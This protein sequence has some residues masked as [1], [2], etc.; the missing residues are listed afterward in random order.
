MAGI[1][2][3]IRKL[4]GR[5]EISSVLAAFVYSGIVSS[6]PWLFAVF[7]LGMIASVGKTLCDAETVN[8]FMGIIIYVFAFSTVL[9]YGTQMAITRFLADCLYR[10]EDNRIPSLLLTSLLLL[11]GIVIVFLTPAIW[12][13]ELPFQVRVQTVFLLV[14][15]TC[16][17]GAMIF[18]ST[19][20]AYVQVSIA[21]VFGFGF[22][23]PASL[24]IG[25]YFGLIG[26]LFGLNFGIAFVVFT[27]CALILKEFSGNLTIEWQVLRA[28]T[29]YPLLFF[30]GLTAGIGIWCDKFI[31]WLHFKIPIGAGLI[32][33]PM[34]DSAMF[35]GYMTVLPSLAYFILIAET[36]L[37]DNIRKYTYLINN[38]GRYE[39]L[40]KVRLNLVNCLKD[41]FIKIG[42]FQ[43]ILT[44]CGITTA[45]VW[46]SV[47][48]LSPLQISILR[49]AMLGAFFQIGMM[50]F[51]IVLT[52]I[53]GERDSFW[54]V[55]IFLGLNS[56]VTYLTL[57]NIWVH[58]YGYFAASFVGFFAAVFF[59]A[60]R[61]KHLHYYL[62]CDPKEL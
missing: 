42:I 38:H 2:F 25:K 59:V 49:I 4:L 15:V 44:I 18:V 36:D 31:F 37:Y 56:S 6:G 60:F 12:L 21:F 19:L 55:L 24:I 34:Y 17:W 33:Y 51:T 3:N 13:L 32:G 16:M 7:A 62:I 58:G 47:L 40:E 48:D 8:L 30:Y 45:P 10:R 1:A 39:A 26:F 20:K 57:G 50:L 61:M 22:A 29:K 23:V 9:T 46:I 27:L 11:G 41:V 43:G 52:Y 53:N 14:L 54:V 5:Q 35:L 28:H